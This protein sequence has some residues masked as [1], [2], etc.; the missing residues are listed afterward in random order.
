[1]NR[2][3]QRTAPPRPLGPSGSSLIEAMVSM[4]LLSVALIGLMGSHVVAARA[5][6]QA[7]RIT[8]ASELAQRV[9]NSLQV[10]RWSDVTLSDQ[11]QCNNTDVDDTAEI[12]VE[13]FPDC[14]PDRQLNPGGAL[15]FSA[16]ARDLRALPG[17]SASDALD[18]NGD[19][20]PD[21]EVFWNVANCRVS[22]TWTFDCVDK[23]NLDANYKRVGVIV[24]WRRPDGGWY[25]VTSSFQRHNPNILGE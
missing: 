12:L 2:P 10:M 14:Q 21:F 16:V 6:G 17:F 8:Q 11:D 5:D 25:R 15:G 4:A 1:M 7:L 19:G 18:Y 20:H 13:D 9:G 3:A 23:A 22:Q 24:R